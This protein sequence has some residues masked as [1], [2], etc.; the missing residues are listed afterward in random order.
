MLPLVAI[1]VSPASAREA[2]CVAVTLVALVVLGD[3]GARL[4][5][6][7]R[8]RAIVR[9]V[10]WGALAMAVTAGIGALLGTAGI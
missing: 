6:A 5:G 10:T 1:A 8:S 7:P 9:V 2:V 3:T 4:G